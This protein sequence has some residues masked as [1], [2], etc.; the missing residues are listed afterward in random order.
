M[1]V[2][3]LSL[4]NEIPSRQVN[5]LD[6]MDIRKLA[7]LDKFKP[8]KNAGGEQALKK[9]PPIS[10]CKLAA[11]FIE[12]SK[13]YSNVFDFEIGAGIL[14]QKM[15]YSP[16]DV[17]QFIRNFSLFLGMDDAHLN[18]GVFISVLLNECFKEGYFKSVEI[19]VRNA[20]DIRHL[21]HKNEAIL[22][23]HGDTGGGLGVAAVAGSITLNGNTDSAAGFAMQGGEV[24][25][26]GSAGTDTGYYMYGGT[27]RINGNIESL[28]TQIIGGDIFQFDRQLV[29]NG[30]IIAQPENK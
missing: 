5:T 30:K 21:G 26:N 13:K 25:V 9:L 1:A 23:I 4:K 24:I 19:D 7:L 15:G 20:P 28:S 16:D 11:P 17:F 8:E 29:K 3:T 22:T 27:L 18:A 2:K 10:S 14:A 6:P 12:L